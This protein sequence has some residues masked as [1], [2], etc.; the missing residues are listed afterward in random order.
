MDLFYF[1]FNFVA[2]ISGVSGGKA[3][4]RIAKRVEREGREGPSSL[5]P[6]P[7]LKSPLPNSRPD[8]QTV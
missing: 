8:I 3:E 1:V 6:P 7:P 4:E 5:F 2:C